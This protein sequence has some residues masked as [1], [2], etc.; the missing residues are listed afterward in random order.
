MPALH[1]SSVEGV[2]MGREAGILLRDNEGI[3]LYHAG[4]TGLFSDMAL[5]GRAG[6]DVALLPIGDKFTMGPDDA[7]TAVELLRPR[8]AIPM[9]YNTWG[10]IAQDPYAWKTTVERRTAAPVMVLD[11]GASVEVMAAVRS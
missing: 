11:P 1:S 5:I 4:D 3:V 6:L 10:T 9:H 8:L 2:A 7:A